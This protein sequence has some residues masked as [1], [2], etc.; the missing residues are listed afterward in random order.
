VIFG[1]GLQLILHGWRL[2]QTCQVWLGV[3]Y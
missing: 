1:D 2:K 3:K